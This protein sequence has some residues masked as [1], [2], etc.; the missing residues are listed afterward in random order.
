[1]KKLYVLL[2]FGSLL[3]FKTDLVAQCGAGY[4]QAQLNWDYLDFLPSSDA[5]YTD[6]YTAA[7]RPYSQDFT[8]GTRRVNFTMAPAANITLDGEN[9]THTGNVG[10]FATA[11]FDVQFTTTSSA[12]TTITMT[13]DA[14]VANVKFSLFDVDNNQAVAI[15]A[16]NTAAVAQSITIAKAN[17]GSAINITGSPGTAPV[18]T[19]PNTGYNNANNLGTINITITG[20]VKTITITLNNATGNIWLGDIDACVTGSFPVGYRSISRPFTG[21]PPYILTV[22]NNQFMLLDPKTG[23]AKGFFTDP[24]WTNMNGMAYDPYNRLLYYTYSLRSAAPGGNAGTKTIFR[25]SVDNETITALVPDVNASPLFIPTYEPGV[26]S[27]S[28]SFYNGSL[29]FGVESS[30]T[31]KN[32]GRENTVWKIDFDASQN[33]IRASQVYAARVDSNISGDDLL[34][35]DWSDIGVTNN[36]MLYDFDG[37]S[38]DPNYYHFNMMSGQRAGFT[39]AVPST[40]LELTPRQLA[41]DWEDSVYNQ[42]GNVNPAVGFVVPYNYNGG[43]VT[44]KLD[45]VKFYPGAS[46]PSG[47]WGDCSEAFRPL[48]DFGDAPASYDPDPWSPAVNEKDTMLH[49]GATF[50]R[51]WNKTSSLLANADGSD[52]D[53]VG[54]VT[55]F[56]TSSS[57]YHIQASVYNHT[58]A[59]ATLIGWL[60]YNGNGLFDASEASAVVSVPSTTAMQNI[61]LMWTGISS[62]LI[63]GTYTYLRIRLTSASHG[64]GTANAT[65][66]YDNGETEDYRVTIT[67]IVLPVQLISFDAKTITNSS[68]QLNWS[69]SGEV[70]VTGYEVQRSCSGSGWEPVAFVPVIQNGNSTNEYELTDN[71]PCKGTSQYRLTWKDANGSARY[72]GIRTVRITDLSPVISVSPNPA[73]NHAT[74]AITSYTTGDLVS[75]KVVDAKGDLVYNHKTMLTAGN[76]SVELPAHRWPSGNYIVVVNTGS[77]TVSQK[78]VVRK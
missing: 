42:G 29:Y 70:D 47:S 15:K 71:N 37:A 35:H 18:A 10:S 12:N 77:A 56:G 22:M 16:L 41:I 43:I 26:T 3:F 64:M 17:V 69:V 4:T 61:D 68:V 67:N 78:L 11:G 5:N 8:I 50:D 9:G 60:D 27:G 66:W 46:I 6:W 13:F 63:P 52:E 14:D 75:I 62:P 51:E 73:G 53:G 36:G 48:C 23:R 20:P 34:I 7:T 72:S 45:T 40:P 44:A 39:V 54:T 21:M 58:G 38:D 31:D 32:S 59:A 28:A 30:N 74:V 49:I 57:N 19:G 65:G 2:F 25:Y 33:P 1:M 55:I 24:G 76:N